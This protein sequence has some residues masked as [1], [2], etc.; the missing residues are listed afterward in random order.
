MDFYNTTE[1]NVAILFCRMNAADALPESTYQP[2]LIKKCTFSLPTLRTPTIID[3]Q[4]A[5]TTFIH[6]I[7]L[8]L[9]AQDS[10]TVHCTVLL[11]TGST[12]SIL[13]A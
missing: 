2:T 1:I 7:S 6:S 8:A 10:N 11:K 13:S 3:L 5:R 12:I 9:P 4:D